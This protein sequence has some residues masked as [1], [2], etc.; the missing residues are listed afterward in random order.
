MAIPIV[1]PA[2]AGAIVAGFTQF[3]ASRGA[4]ILAG[5]GLTFVG[6]KGFETV[7]GFAI[8]DIQ[9]VASQAAGGGG[10][11]SDAMVQMAAYAGLFDYINIVLSGYSAFASIVG[12]RFIVGRL[13]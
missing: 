11:H 12:L 3:L 2:I 9:Q 5:L 10:G 7:I 8:Q 1:F 4:A 6:V 13:K